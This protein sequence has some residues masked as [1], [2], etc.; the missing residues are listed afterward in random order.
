MPDDDNGVDEDLTDEDLAGAA[1]LLDVTRDLADRV[2]R[3]EISAAER[4]A[5][6]ADLTELAS[7]LTPLQETAPVHTALGGRL[8]GRGHPLLPPVVR[9]PD[10]GRVRG[11][12]MFTTAHA[13]AGLA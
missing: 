5:L 11:T 10:G 6:A 8:P 2:W 9:T 3:T 7:R 12:V 1:A 4:R 13:G